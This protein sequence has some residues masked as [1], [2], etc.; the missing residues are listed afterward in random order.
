MSR[1]V[2]VPSLFILLLAA[3]YYGFKDILS[4]EFLLARRI[5]LTNFVANHPAPSA[6]TF[7]LLCILGGLFLPGAMLLL[8]AGG[9]LFGVGGGMILSIVGFLCSALAA[10]VMVRGI[11]DGALPASVKTRAAPFRR[12]LERNGFYYLLFLRLVPLLPFSVVN[13]CAGAAGISLKSFLLATVLGIL[14]VSFICVQAGSHL[15][16]IGAL[17]EILSPPVLVSLSLLGCLALFPALLRRS[18]I[19]E[20]LRARSNSSRKG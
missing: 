12:E 3:S 9:W 18:G 10:F 4:L 17:N 5:E 19:Y 1:K 14:P 16:E 15:A 20:V 11:Y 2:I 8:V 13:L 6:G 7:F